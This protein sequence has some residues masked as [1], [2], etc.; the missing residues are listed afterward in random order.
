MSKNEEISKLVQDHINSKSPV[1][2]VVGGF[3]EEATVLELCKIIQLWVE[4]NGTHPVKIGYGKDD[5]GYYFSVWSPAEMV[6]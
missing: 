3:S 2:L 1:S 5:K 6:Q 4:N